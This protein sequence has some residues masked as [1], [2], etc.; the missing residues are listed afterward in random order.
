VPPSLLARTDE[1][2]SEPAALQH[3][4]GGAAVVWRSRR[5]RNSLAESG[6]SVCS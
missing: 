6:A 4:L 2:I 3:P 1:V 5:V